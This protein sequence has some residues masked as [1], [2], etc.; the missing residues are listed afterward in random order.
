MRKKELVAL[1]RGIECG[2]G[3]Y[4]NFHDEETVWQGDTSH[5]RLFLQRN[6][7]GPYPYP[8]PR[9]FYTTQAVVE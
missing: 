7:V 6:S 5:V 2:C 4:D 9:F 3:E 1:C 8:P